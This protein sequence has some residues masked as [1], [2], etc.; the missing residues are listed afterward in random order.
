MLR[1]HW[2]IQLAL[3]FWYRTVTHASPGLQITPKSTCSISLFSIDNLSQVLLMDCQR[4]MCRN[5]KCVC[6]EAD[7]NL[8][9]AVALELF[10]QPSL[11]RYSSCHQAPLCPKSWNYK[12][13]YQNTLAML[14]HPW[15]GASLCVNTMLE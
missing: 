12:S 10:N 8:L 15:H 7:Y 2:N 6:V 14:L 3:A 4:K 13:L 9:I 1:W 5:D 11:W